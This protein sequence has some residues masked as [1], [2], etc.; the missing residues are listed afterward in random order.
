MRTKQVRVKPYSKKWP[1][2]FQRF[3]SY[4]HQWL[5]KLLLRVEHVGSTSV[6]GLAAKPILDIDL[7]IVRENF[8]LVRTILENHGYYYEGDLG[9]KDRE[10]FSYSHLSFFSDQ[11]VPTHHLYVCPQ[12]SEQ[13]HQHLLFRNFLRAHPEWVARYGKLKMSLALAHPF[14]IEEYIAGKHQLVN[15]ILDLAIQEDLNH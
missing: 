15:E 3:A 6:P 1:L 7:V 4:Y 12:D 5:G 9:I 8:P 13:L 10:A 14:D 11:D 2:Y